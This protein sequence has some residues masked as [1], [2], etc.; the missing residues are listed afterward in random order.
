MSVEVPER[1]Q[2]TMNFIKHWKETC[3][4]IEQ[5]GEAI[6]AEV[7]DHRPAPDA[8]T[9]ELPKDRYSTKEEI[10][11]ALRSS[12][13]DASKALHRRSGLNHEITEMILTFIEHN[14]EHYGQLA[15]YA[16]Q[17]GIVPPAS[18]T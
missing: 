4:K 16:R 11:G 10:I 14:S 15:V 13:A 1:E 18:R 17:N 7:F 6:P 2:S 12:G 8:R 9:N 5:L 3:H